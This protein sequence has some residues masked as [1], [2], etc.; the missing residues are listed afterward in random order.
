MPTSQ[1]G[2]F[3]SERRLDIITRPKK[4]LIELHNILATSNR[5]V[6]IMK[7][8]D[9]DRFQQVIGVVTKGTSRV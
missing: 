7:T 4:N 5:F 9:F 1:M 3:L 2:I 8:L 6:P